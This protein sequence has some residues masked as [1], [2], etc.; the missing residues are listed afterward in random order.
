M[1]VRLV[2]LDKEF[3]IILFFQFQV[4]FLIFRVRQVLAQLLDL[5]CQILQLSQFRSRWL[6]LLCRYRR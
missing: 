4:T 5:L 3:S 1:V 6:L 2:Y